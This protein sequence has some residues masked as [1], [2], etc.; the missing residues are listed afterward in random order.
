M[1]KAIGLIITT[2]ALWTMGL[3]TGMAVYRPLVAAPSTIPDTLPPVHHPQRLQSVQPSITVVGTITT[4]PTRQRDGDVT[5]E[6]QSGSQGYHAEIVCVYPPTFAAARV[7]CAGY[8]NRIAIPHRGDRVRITGP[9]MRDLRHDES[10]HE[11]EI[12]PVTA[13]VI[14]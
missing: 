2:V 12:H 6:V 5:F 3:V 1:R 14:L 13:L 8:T 10:F 7:A 4:T 11:L 9:L